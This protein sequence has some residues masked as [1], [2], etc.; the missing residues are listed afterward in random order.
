MISLCSHLAEQWVPLALGTTTLLGA[1]CLLSFSRALRLRQHAAEFSVA[2]A[3]LFAACA[4]LPLPRPWATGPR[5][6]ALEPTSRTSASD[7]GR[8]LPEAR[9]AAS[10]LAPRPREAEVHAPP[11]D[12]AARPADDALA[13]SSSAGAAQPGLA[14]PI[15]RPGQP[16]PAAPA[17]FAAG[18]RAA[19]T[20]AGHT[21]GASALRVT[22]ACHLSG[23][24]LAALWL[25]L[26]WIRLRRVLRAAVPAPAAW[27]SWLAARAAPRACPRLLVSAGASRP[28]CCGLRRPV[29]VLPASLWPERVPAG[30]ADAGTGGRADLPSPR[31]RA[32][33]STGAP[34]AAA[35]GDVVAAVLL[36]ELAHLRRADHRRALLFAAAMPVLFPQPLFW[37]L[38]GR[39]RRAS[40]MVA[41]AEAA[42]GC[43]G[44]TRYAHRLLDLV[45]RSRALSPPAAVAGVVFVFRRPSDLTERI[46]M[47]T[48]D[49]L[50]SRSGPHHARGA[51]HAGL[52]AA[53][54]VLCVGGWGAAP[55]SA[56]QASDED[57]L[58]ELRRER[59]LLREEVAALRRDLEALRAQS[60]D[61]VLGRLTDDKA[62]R[63]FLDV[64]PQLDHAN[65]LTQDQR[66]QRKIQDFLVRSQEA[67]SG[68]DGRTTEVE[69]RAG[70]SLH[71]L[72][73]RFHTE[74]ERILRLNPGLEPQRLR[75]GQNVIVPAPGDPQS[76]VSDAPRADRTDPSPQPDPLL[77]APRPHGDHGAPA[78]TDVGAIL[79][80]MTQLIDLEGQVEQAR[81]HVAQVHRS[82]QPAMAREA[83]EIGLRTTERK[84]DL[85][86]RMVSLERQSL[87]AEIG[88]Q[89]A[90]VSAA[91]KLQEQGFLSASELDQMKVKLMR[92]SAQLQMLGGDSDARAPDADGDRKDERKKKGAAR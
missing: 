1:G 28:F 56:Q 42:T 85:V 71:S 27:Q 84:L 14:V 6:P 10:G 88:A 46:E 39:A 37:W 38:R 77:A 16:R 57:A 24:A 45:E 82:D 32:G 92:L 80:L 20:G 21:D 7:A 13:S 31:E 83:A 25:V 53:A 29:I 89:S 44:R 49:R 87:Q 60:Q 64:L 86:R 41:D 61:G 78:P 15:E 8:V 62:G 35:V 90:H 70:D 50:R 18:S 26:G 63:T 55:V 5:G 17:A 72:A 81:L 73:Q 43:G 67:S 74:V 36:H 23:T 19:T 33:A 12:A 47:L 69:V 22:V 66:L 4:L 2:A 91:V 9:A 79:Q 30:R 75:V 34:E 58:R 52:I 65:D 51:F 3:L 48:N 68:A 59:D 40:E 54:T 11:Q 76:V